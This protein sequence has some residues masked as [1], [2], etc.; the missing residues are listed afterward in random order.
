MGLLIIIITSQRFPTKFLYL[1]V[2]IL[3]L[4]VL[5]LVFYILSPPVIRWTQ[6]FRIKRKHN[7]VIRNNFEDLKYFIE[8]FEEF[9]NVDGRNN[10]ATV[11]YTVGV[12]DDPLEK[13]VITF[14]I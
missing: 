4:A 10:I 11:L 9:V 5:I 1:S 7:K 8:K 12:I 2:G 3:V 13:N 14:A 6:K